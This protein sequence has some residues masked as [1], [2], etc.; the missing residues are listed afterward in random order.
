METIQESVKETANKM[1][2]SGKSIDFGVKVF[3]KQL[4]Q[5]KKYVVQ[6]LRGEY[7]A[8]VV[9]IGNNQLRRELLRRLQS[10]GY[11]IPVLIHPTAYV[12]QSAKIGKG[13]VVEPK[14]IVNTGSQVGEGCIIS[15][16]AIVDHDVI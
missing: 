13:T 12:S 9:G 1:I 14:A 11:R 5:L 6:E 16:G 10:Y 15:A 4:E 7:N 8:A 3:E 2:F